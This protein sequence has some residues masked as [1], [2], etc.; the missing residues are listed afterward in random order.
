MFTGLRPGEKLHEVLS[1]ADEASEAR[2]HPQIS[3]CTVPPLAGD[4]LSTDLLVRP[5][6]TAQ[7]AAA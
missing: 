1:S 4:D 6:T 7:L 3:H 2:V 5:V